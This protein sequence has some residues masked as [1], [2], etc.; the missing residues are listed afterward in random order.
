MWENSKPEKNHGPKNLY[1]VRSYYNAIP[2]YKN[3]H[4]KHYTTHT[5]K[6]LFGLTKEQMFFLR[7][8]NFI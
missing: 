5:T 2:N 7:K 6:S 8:V 4:S 3:T 1:H